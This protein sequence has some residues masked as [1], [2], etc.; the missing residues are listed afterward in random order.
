MCKLPGEL[1]ARNIVQP[2]Q[3]VHPSQ[4]AMSSMAT[5][6]FGTTGPTESEPSMHKM[7]GLS[8]AIGKMSKYKLPI[9]D[10]SLAQVQCPPQKD[11]LRIHE[12]S[13]FTIA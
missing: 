6:P 13:R 2:E 8:V 11:A 4:A 10:I 5:Q 9:E 7:V 1:D 3:E 12:S